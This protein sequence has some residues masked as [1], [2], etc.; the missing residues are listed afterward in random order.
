MPLRIGKDKRTVYR[1]AYNI[2]NVT[3]FKRP[4]FSSEEHLKIVKNSFIDAA[5]ELEL[6]LDNVNVRSS[7]VS[8]RLNID[9]SESPSQVFAKIKFSATKKMNERISFL[10]KMIFAK[11]FMITTSGE[12][13]SN[14]MDLIEYI[15]DVKAKYNDKSRRFN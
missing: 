11:T 15:D 14:G 8:F 9:P 6:H 7:I 13:E 12:N 5:E 10:P 4:L 3:R 1:C 2:A